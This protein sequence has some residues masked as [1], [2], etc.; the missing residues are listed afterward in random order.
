MIL[1]EIKKWKTSQGKSS[2]LSL[3]KTHG[4]FM[5]TD[6]KSMNA[7][8]WKWWVCFEFITAIKCKCWAILWD[9]RIFLHFQSFFLFFSVSDATLLNETRKSSN[10][11]KRKSFLRRNKTEEKREKFNYGSHSKTHHHD[12]PFYDFFPEKLPS[13]CVCFF[14]EKQQQ[15]L[16]VQRF[17][18]ERKTAINYL[19][20]NSKLAGEQNAGK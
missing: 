13:V 16:F 17:C 12:S 11:M 9:W 18:C 15:K 3:I 8:K 14:P 5:L 6:N 1:V 7:G 19:F 2:I 10:E 4:N 20:T